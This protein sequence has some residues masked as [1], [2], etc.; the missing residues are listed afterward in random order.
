MPADNF[1][2]YFLLKFRRLCGFLCGFVFYLSGIF[3]LMDPVGAGLVM[4]GYLD[5]FHLDFL[6]FAAKG[7]G[8]IFALVEVVIGTALVTGVWRKTIAI[9][10]FSL[11]GFFTLLTL[12]LVIFNPQMDCGCFGE[13]IHLTHMETFVKNLILCTLLCVAFIPLKNLGRPKRRKYVSFG[14]V[15]LSSLAFSLYSLMYVPM[16]DHTEFKPGVGLTAAQ[17]DS[18]SDSAYEA[19][20]IYEK[21]GQQQEFTLEELPDST[22]T[23]VETRTSQN[24]DALSEGV[25]LSFYDNEDNYRDSLATGENVMIFSVYDTDIKQKK[26]DKVIQS[27]QSAVNSGFSTFILTA[28]TPEQMADIDTGDIPIYFGDYKTLVT[29]NRSNGGATWLCQGYLVKKWSRRGFPDQDTLTKDIRSNATEIILEND[30][31]GSLLFQGFLLYV[32]AV[33]LLL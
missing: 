7:L 19:V 14:L 33:M 2:K 10:A 29:L 24:E 26:W 1:F 12:I 16:V 11:Q 28:S 27:A 18:E 32:F 13:V 8:V 30:A 3:K 31:E 25:T 20:F 6:G 9:A 22:W 23:F 21:D 4:D 5:F 17:N 15:C